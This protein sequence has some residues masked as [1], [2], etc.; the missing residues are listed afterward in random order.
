MLDGG[1]S[2]MSVC[3]SCHAGC[4]RSFAVPVTGADI[5]RLERAE[6]LDF[7]DF[8][9]RWADPL[10]HIA[11]NY[12]P[13]F[14]FRDEPQTPFVICLTHVP[15]V[16]FPGT[17]KCRFLKETPP[18]EEHPNG[19]GRCGVYEAR[20]GACRAFPTKLNS[21]NELAVIY[22]VPERGRAVDS[23]AYNLC[24]RPWEPADFEPISTLQDLV[25]ARF[26]MNFFHQLAR[27]WNRAP[28]DWGLFPEFLRLAYAGRVVKEQPQEV[29]E[30]EEAAEPQTL[31]FPGRDA[32]RT[33]R[34][35]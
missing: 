33:N 34:A 22:D 23:P 17:T 29:V 31:P 4:C 28:R 16:S 11:R 14:H 12:A 19:L 7:W 25:V 24:P 10:G 21:S 30:T 5:L 18:S 15:S 13:H 9:C 1:N 32:A 2:T 3:D 35:A 27:V 8:A 6:G 26:E 20:P